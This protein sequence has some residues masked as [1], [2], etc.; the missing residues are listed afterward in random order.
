MYCLGRE[1]GDEFAVQWRVNK[2]EVDCDAHPARA[3]M[4]IRRPVRNAGSEPIEHAAPRLVVVCSGCND[5]LSIVLR[6]RSK[7]LVQILLH[8]GR[9]RN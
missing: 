2:V 4:N 5:F 7:A 6:T 1:T 3:G 9:S 8:Q